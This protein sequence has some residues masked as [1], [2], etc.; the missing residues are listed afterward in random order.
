MEHVS[1]G[2]HIQVEHSLYVFVCEQQIWEVLRGS[3][4]R[5]YTLSNE[6][7]LKPERIS[8]QLLRHESNLQARIIIVEIRLPFSAFCPVRDMISW[9]Q[10]SNE[11]G[12]L[13]TSKDM[14][15]YL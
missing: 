14:K 13:L 6:L 5:N 12:V 8:D 4:V 9:R 1:K 15:C 7:Q 3:Y 11:R 2:V 10:D